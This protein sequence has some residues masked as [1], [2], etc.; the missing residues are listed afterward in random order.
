MTWLKAFIAKE[1]VLVRALVGAVLGVVV[2]RF[3]LDPNVQAALLLAITGGVA[4]WARA[5]VTPTK[6]VKP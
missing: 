6:K 1:P 4:A 5:K 3:H 2:T